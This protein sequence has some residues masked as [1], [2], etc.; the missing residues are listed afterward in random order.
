M[1]SSSRSSRV[2]S[3]VKSSRVPASISSSTAAAR[4]CICSVLSLAR[5]MARPVSA[6]SSPIPPAAAPVPPS[7]SG[8]A[9]RAARPARRGFAFAPLLLD[10]GGLQMEPLLRRHDVCDALLHLLQ[11]LELLFV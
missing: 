7:A 8:G 2:L 5:W 6:I 11:H 3:E 10:L 4:A 9:A 1:A